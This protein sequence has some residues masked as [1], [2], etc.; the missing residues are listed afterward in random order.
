MVSN[1]LPFRIIMATTEDLTDRLEKDQIAVLKEQFHVFDLDGNGFIDYDELRQGLKRLGYQ[2]SDEGIENLFNLVGSKDQRLNFE[3]FIAWKRE[4]YI[5]DMKDRFR[6][7]DTDQSG[8]IGRQEMMAYYDN[9]EYAY[10]EE[11]IDD[12][13]YETDFNEDGK[14]QIDEFIAGMAAS[15]TGNAFFVLNCEMFLAK[16]KLEFQAMDAN[17]DGVVTREELREGSTLS[18]KEIELTF[19]ELDTDGDGQISLQ[20]F[21]AAAVSVVF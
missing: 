5:Q 20:E 2:L 1:Q 18:P 17:G 21:I 6:E 14:M 7:I 10:T 12:F 9:M 11:E 15:S 19:K 4:L 8:W 16:L 13:L 3:Q